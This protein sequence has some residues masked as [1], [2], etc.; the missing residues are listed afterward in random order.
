MLHMHNPYVHV[1]QQAGEL[2]THSQLLSCLLNFSPLDG[3]HGAITAQHL[4][5]LVRR[6]NGGWGGAVPLRT[7]GSNV[8]SVLT[9]SSWCVQKFT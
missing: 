6:K 9:I 8:P 2:I 5:L 7:D 4:K 3:I 1:F